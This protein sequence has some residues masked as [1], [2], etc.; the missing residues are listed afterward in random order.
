LQ[1]GEP[2]AQLRPGVGPFGHP[3]PT[4]AGW[5]ATAPRNAT[6]R[7]LSDVSEG[8]KFFVIVGASFDELRSRFHIR[9]IRV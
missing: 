1:L 6:T 9:P 2:M 3:A 8:H 4:P 5:P 7:K